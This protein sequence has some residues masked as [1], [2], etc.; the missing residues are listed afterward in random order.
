M[1]IYPT[2]QLMEGRCVSLF[3]GRTE[4]PTIW[5][6]DPLEKAKEFY[7]AG[8]EWMHITD[9]DAME[10]DYRNFDLILSIIRQ[11]GISVQL[12]GGFRSQERI[13]EW[14]DLGVGRVVLGTLAVQNPD[15]AKRAAKFFPDQIVISVDVWQGSVMISGWRGKSAIPPEKLVEFYHYSPI[16]GYIVT[17]IDS[18]VDERESSLA[19]ITSFAK[20]AQS[21]VIA[22]GLIRTCDDVSRL[23]YVPNVAGAMVGTALLEKTVELDEALAIAQPIPETRAEFI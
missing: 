10:G 4:E 14:I 5:H 13:E 11:V 17:D 1:I 2:I 15:W 6:V 23:K 20:L 8:A 9:F 22:S 7:A 16:A 12:G 21:P 3:R 19:L 18:S